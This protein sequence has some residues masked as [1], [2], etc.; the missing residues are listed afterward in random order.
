MASGFSWWNLSTSSSACTCSAGSQLS[1]AW[2]YPLHL[3][4]YCSFFPHPC[5]L[6]SSTCSTSYSSS[7]STRSGGSSGKF[8][9]CSSVSLYGKRRLAWKTGC[10]FF[11]FHCSGNSNWKETGLITST[12]LNGSYRFGANFCVGCEVRRF[13]PSNQT[14]SPS[15][16][17]S[18]ALH[19]FCFTLHF[20]TIFCAFLMAS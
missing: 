18:Y 10:T 7:P 1:W 20:M 14:R 12:T 17:G 2:E 3:R 16:Y 13:F 9:P 6:K 8:A 5:H 15:L 19:P 4:R 11:C